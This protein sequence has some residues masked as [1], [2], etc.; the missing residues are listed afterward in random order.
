MHTAAQALLGEHD[1]SSFRAA[2]C[3]SPT[4]LR[5]VI[6]IGVERVDA[7]VTISVRANAFLHHMVRNIAGALIA[8]GTGN[9][10]T[11]WIG[12]L[13]DARDRRQGAVTAPPQG[14]YL[15]RVEYPDEFGIPP[16]DAHG[17]CPR[18]PGV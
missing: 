9:R 18:P 10:P 5:T 6:H 16:T 14:L 4:A 3:Q 15:S 13:L 11:S 1:F 12:A 17:P 8:V 7:T 2:E